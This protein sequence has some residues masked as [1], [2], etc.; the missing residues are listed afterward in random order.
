MERHF[1]A[2]A[3]IFHEERALLHFHRKLGKWLPPGGHVEP[4]ETPPE[5]ALREAKEETGLDIIILEQENLKIDA[6]NGVS[7]P[8]P[9]LCLLEHIPAYKD[10]PAHQHMDMIYIARPADSCLPMNALSDFRWFRY[11]E[12][13]ELELFPDVAEVL[14]LLLKEKKLEEFYQRR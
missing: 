11:E 5:A 6:Y 1:T 4:N 2:T 12:T 14:R 13:Q 3:Y 10:K 7:F 9:F 8:R